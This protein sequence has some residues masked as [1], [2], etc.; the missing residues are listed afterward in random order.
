MQLQDTE[1]TN[2]NTG[3]TWAFFPGL[4]HSGVMWLPLV[5]EMQKRGLIALNDKIFIVDTFGNTAGKE[6]IER[7]FGQYGLEPQ[8]ISSTVLGRTRGGGG[9]TLD[10]ALPENAIGVGYSIGGTTML[11]NLQNPKALVFLSS[12]AEYTSVGRSPVLRNPLIEITELWY[13]VAKLAWPEF[14]TEYTK[15]FFRLCGMHSIF[16]LFKRGTETQP[17]LKQMTG[18]NRIDDAR[19]VLASLLSDDKVRAGTAATIKPELYG[20]QG[21]YNALRAD[22]IPTIALVGEDD[23]IVTPEMSRHS[24]GDDVVQVLRGE[25]HALPYANP[26][27]VAQ[28]LGNFLLEQALIQSPARN[29]SI[30]S[31]RD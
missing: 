28:L 18:K 1:A 16:Q 22:D 2:S 17:S 31:D 5:L 24:L 12:F 10:Q 26:T 6:H 3:N 19:A 14:Q 25:T 15:E 30:G 23:F 8:V 29:F 9:L 27:L 11:E 4:A 20:Q 7:R 21:T 13:S